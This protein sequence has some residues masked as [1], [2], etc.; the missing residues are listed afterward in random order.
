MEQRQ[1]NTR[2]RWHRNQKGWSQRKVADLIYALS[3]ENGE[4]CG[5]TGNL[6][7]RWERGEIVPS[8]FY[9]EKLCQAFDLSPVELGLLEES[10]LVSPAPTPAE[11]PTE[12]SQITEGSALAASE[13]EQQQVF[14]SLPAPE[15]D[16][17][18]DAEQL[19]EQDM[20]PLRRQITWQTLKLTGAAVV[21][22]QTALFDLDGAERLLQVLSKPYHVDERTIHYLQKRIWG[23]WQDRNDVA[24]PTRDLL[25]Y[26]IE[27]LQRI[28]NLLGRSLLPN[29]RVELC[30]LTSVAA[31]LIGELYFDL[32]NYGQARV[33][34]DIAIVAAQEANDLVLEAVVWGR[35]S[36]AW[37]YDGKPH[38]A[39][40]CIQRARGISSGANSVVCGWLAAVEAEIQANRNDRESCLKALKEA[41]PI[42]NQH[43]QRVESYWIHFDSSLAAGYHGVS[44]LRLASFGHKDLVRSAQDVLLDALKLLDPSMKRR[45]LTLLVDLAGTYV[46]QKNIEQACENAMKAMDIANQIKSKVS[47]LRLLTLREGL[48]PWKEA[49]YVKNLDEKLT[50]LVIQER[51]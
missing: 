5:I 46:Y 14:P 6:V 10:P 40:I 29:L 3:V 4:G 15:Q 45:Q 27:D 41:P 18:G 9:R 12:G 20:D 1:P 36:F 37:T 11:V 16:I 13:H 49:Q 21:T 50:S 34:H 32:G 43:D 28:T 22:S 35:K 7:S 39:L 30:L 25:P 26:V 24:I 17:I 8:P 51:R 44:F 33:F 19:E 2:L 38:A 42:E 31:M 23:Y 48:D 47:L